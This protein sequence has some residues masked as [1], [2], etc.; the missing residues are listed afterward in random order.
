LGPSGEAEG[1]GRQAYMR[2]S[3][4]D[5]AHATA[6]KPSARRWADFWGGHLDLDALA[7]DITDPPTDL[8]GGRLRARGGNISTE[9]TL[10]L[11]QPGGALHP[12]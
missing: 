2:R 6:V 1:C 9:S 11:S 3:L 10:M 5:P 12:S 4:A 7:V 8:E